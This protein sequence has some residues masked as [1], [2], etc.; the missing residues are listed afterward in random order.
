MLQ[1]SAH[2]F[3]LIN[4]TCVGNVLILAG[5]VWGQNIWTEIEK[6]ILVPTRLFY[7]Q[8]LSNTQ[9]SRSAI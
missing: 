3:Y 5:S 2:G 7:Q 9:H 1:V 4:D 8:Q 6:K